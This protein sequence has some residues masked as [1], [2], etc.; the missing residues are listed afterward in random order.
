MI[1]V[2]NQSRFFGLDLGPWGRD[3]MTAWRRMLDWPV[4]A[5]LWPKLTVRLIFPNGTTACCRGPGEP[6]CDT[7]KDLTLARAARFEA[8][9]LPEDI[10]LRHSL[11]LPQLVPQELDAA[12]GL[13]LPLLSPFAAD[14][15]AWV[16]ETVSQGDQSVHVHLVLTSRKLIAQY[17]LQV[18]PQLQN[19]M[20]EIWASHGHR[21]GYMVF[22]GFAE[23]LRHR[24]S[25]VWRWVSV[26]LVFFT[27]ALL[28]TIAVTPSVQLYSRILQA[29][30]A[31]SAMQQKAAPVLK[32]RESLVH[33]TDQLTALAKLVGKPLPPLQ[34][35]NLV[36]QSLPDDTSLLSMQVQGT[37]VTITG[38]TGNAAALMKQ[39]GATPGLHDVTAPT[40]A[41]KPL[42]APRESFSIEFMLDAV[43]PATTP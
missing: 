29:N 42:G 37:K 30:L 38:Q 23:T 15:L 19:P 32:Q 21:P 25:A 1:A 17:L 27:L 43:L 18:Q 12:L 9:V 28:M 35:L 24:Q 16:Y 13:Q 26:A 41:T 11:V 33:A 22:S 34:V 20:P 7:P 8:L 6:S 14:D 36:T 40:P 4:L 3:I 5:W 31:M 2:Q 39:L 10:L